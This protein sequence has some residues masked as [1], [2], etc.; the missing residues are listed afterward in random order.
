MACLAR[1]PKAW[2][3]SGQSFPIKTDA[4]G[5]VAVHDFDGVAVRDGDD[6]AGKQSTYEFQG[7][8]RVRRRV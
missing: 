8:Q 6:G 1:V 5:I 4:F 3:F 7:K 2:S